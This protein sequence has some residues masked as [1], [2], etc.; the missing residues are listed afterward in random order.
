[1]LLAAPRVAQADAPARVETAASAVMQVEALDAEGKA[2]LI[3]A[4]FLAGGDGLLV[5][6]YHV[7]HNASAA[8]AKAA[9]GGSFEVAG[10]AAADKASDLAAL[11]LEGGDSPSLALGDSRK[12]EAGARIF[13]VGISSEGPVSE[14]T[15]S[16]VRETESGERFLEITAAVPEDS[17]GCP[18]VDGG[19]NVVG[20]ATALPV[21]GG[22]LTFAVPVENVR[23]LLDGKSEVR[24]LADL[25][26]GKAEEYLD[27]EEG[28]RFVAE[29]H[30]GRKQYDEADPY[31]E[32]AFD[33]NPEAAENYFNLAVCH[34]KVRQNLLGSLDAFQQAIRLKPDFVRAHYYEGI[35][36]AKVRRPDDAINSYK[37]TIRLK[38][39]FAEAHAKLCFV[40]NNSGRHEEA[41]EACKQA[42]RLKPDYARAHYLLGTAYVALDR[43]GDALKEH[44]TLKGLDEVLAGKLLRTVEW[45]EKEEEKKEE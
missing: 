5:T 36:Y 34:A 45:A 17:S 6:S 8:T 31:V 33:L 22:T 16:A 43:R 39:D 20:V 42:I 26:S 12:L 7:V 27:T 13:A 40:Y 9:D 25:R 18:V 24:A 23:E 30:I 2:F 29:Y 41:V 28:N 4:G 37:E 11:K 38:P 15:V 10:V 32:K 3:G 19:G 21:R 44:E 35:M 14:G 1:M